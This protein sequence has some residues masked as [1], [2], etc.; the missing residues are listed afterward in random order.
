METNRCANRDKSNHCLKV[1]I[2]RNSVESGASDHHY[3]VS[4]HTILLLRTKVASPAGRES[5]GAG[6]V[7]R[8]GCHDPRSGSRYGPFSIHIPVL[9]PCRAARGAA[10]AGASSS[11]SFSSSTFCFFFFCF[12]CFFSF[13]ASRSRP[14][15]AS[16]LGQRGRY[17]QA[18]PRRQRLRSLSVIWRSKGAGKGTRRSLVN[19]KAQSYRST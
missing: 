13:L 17:G 19:P 1:R 4:C 14:T 6:S 11:S 3:P 2:G 8:G 15:T 12:F 9:R 10:G 18:A 16:H 7:T 5:R